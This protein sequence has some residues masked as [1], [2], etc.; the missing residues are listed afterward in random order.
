MLWLDLDTCLSVSQ[1]VRALHRNR[2]ATGSIPEGLKLHFSQLFL[3]T[4]NKWFVK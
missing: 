4:S 1:L 2:R 3:V